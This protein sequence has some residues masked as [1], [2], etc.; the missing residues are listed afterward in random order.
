MREA[1]QIILQRHQMLRLPQKK[2]ALIINP[3]EA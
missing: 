3:L 1:P 2:K